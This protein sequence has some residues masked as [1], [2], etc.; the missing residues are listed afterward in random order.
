M[1]LFFLMLAPEAGAASTQA[2]QSLNPLQ[3]LLGQFGAAPMFLLVF[4][5][6]YFMLIRP[7]QTKQKEHEA[8]QKRVG[9]G[10][11]VVTTGG[12]VGKITH[13]ADDVLTIEVG[14]KVRVRVLRSHVTGKAP[15][16][17]KPGSEKA[18]AEK[19]GQKEKASA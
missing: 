19:A 2:A 15:G 10:D 17:D 8:W 14:D 18:G 13:V 12:L 9:Q 3:K 6:F 11:E 4:V 1:P 16:S 5:V 7:Q